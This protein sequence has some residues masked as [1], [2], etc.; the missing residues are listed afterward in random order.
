M[1]EKRVLNEDFIKNDFYDSEGNKINTPNEEII[2]KF[3]KITGIKERRYVTDDLNTSDI[4][5]FA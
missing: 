5:Y 2:Q 3:E 4:A 1:P